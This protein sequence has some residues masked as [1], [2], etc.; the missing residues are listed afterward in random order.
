M[1]QPSDAP[2]MG[3]VYLRGK[4]WWHHYSLNG[5]LIR[6]RIPD[7]APYPKCK[8][9]RAVKEHNR[10]VTQY[11]AAKKEEKLRR[12]RHELDDAAEARAQAETAAAGE[13]RMEDAWDRYLAARN[14]PQSGEGTLRDYRHRWD[15]F[16][17]WW[18]REHN[19]SHP[20]FEHV[21][22]AHAEAFASWLDAQRL[23][24]N[25]YNKIIQTCRLVFTVLSRYRRHRPNP[26]GES[27]RAGIANKTLTTN[28]RRDLSEAEAQLVI[29]NATGE[30]RTLF[31]LGLY[32]A[33]R[34][35][36]CATLRWDEVKWQLN[37][38]VRVP[39]KL[40]RHGKTV[41]IPMFHAV[42]EALAQTPPADR[43]DY[44]L[45]ELATT[46]ETRSWILTKRIRKHLQNCGIRRH[47]K[48]TGPGTGKRAVV[49]VGFHS[50]RH[51]FVTMLANA[52]A[53][54]PVVQALAGHGS[55]AIQQVYLHMGPDIT[56]RAI[57]SLPDVAI[58]VEA[59]VVPN[60]LVDPRRILESALA[61][62]DW[63]LVR[64]ALDVLQ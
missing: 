58:D 14:R 8:H 31:V 62:H 16:V 52:G 27:A 6:E 32:T 22:E 25:R 33:M 44:V 56:R 2:I 11:A 64:H 13:L 45:P 51:T 23:S 60:D 48:G 39:R 34:L 24:P 43:R 5:V 47:R 10:L 3:N 50:L 9:W 36:D 18:M 29:N 7:L 4:R 40:R 37:Q 46:Y 28:R 1:P 21:R 41:V 54:L 20:L 63:G 55:A 61:A 49:E 35:G 53:P 42:R 15:K 19:H 26:F 30:L 38:I 12:I 59:E 17:G 57:E